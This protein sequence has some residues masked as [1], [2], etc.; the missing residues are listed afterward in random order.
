[1]NR[2]SPFGNANEN[3][4]FLLENLKIHKPRKINENHIFCLLK[5]DNKKF[6]DAIA[7]NV[8]N[9]KIEDYLLNYKNKIKVLCKFNLS[10]NKNNKTNIHIVDII[11]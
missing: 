7:F 6:F 5:G 1:M 3:P 2:L 8:M 10:G 9:T 4:V 11:I